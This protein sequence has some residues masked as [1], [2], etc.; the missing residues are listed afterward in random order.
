[1][2][3]TMD[4]STIIDT[5]KLHAKKINAERL[6]DAYEFAA[7]AHD[8]Q[9]RRSGEPYIQHCL[10]ATYTLAKLKVD[11]DTLIA[12]LLHDVPE[13]TMYTIQDVK[14]KFGVEVAYLVNGVTKL[15]KVQYKDNM[16]E[17]Q[18]ESL[19]KMFLVMAK[20]LR[21]VLIKLADRLHNMETLSAVRPEK[22][23]RI[24]KETLEIFAPLADRLGIWDIKWKLEDLCFKYIYP[25]QYAKLN[26]EIQTGSEER[27]KYIERV[28]DTLSKELN[29]AGIETKI[30]GRTKHLY[31]IYMKMIAKK[32]TLSEIYDIFALRI[33]VSDVKNCYAALGIVHDVWKPKPGR[34]KDYIAVPKANGYQSLHTTVFAIDGRLTEFQIRTNEMHE[35]AEYGVAAHWHY[36]TTKQSPGQLKGKFSRAPAEQLSWV[37][38]LVEMQETLKDNREFIEGLKID[39]FKD[40]IFVFT[41]M[42]EVK[43]L[44]AG[45]TCVDFAYAVHTDLGHS[46]M[47]AK[48]NG[49]MVPLDTTLKTGDIIEILASKVPQGPKR[50]WLRFV[51][52]NHARNKIRSW[53]REENMQINVDHGMKLLDDELIRLGKGKVKTLSRQRI[54]EFLGNAEHTTLDDVLA[55]IGEGSL[56]VTNAVRNLFQPEEILRTQQPATGI[57]GLLK[58]TRH[59]AAT[60]A[61]EPRVLIEGQSNMLTHFGKCCSPTAADE[62]V[63]FIT[64][65]KGITIHR[66]NC[67]SLKNLDRDRIIHVSWSTAPATPALYRVNIVVEGSDRI[68]LLRD[69]I[70]VLSDLSINIH[71]LNAHPKSKKEASAI[72]DEFTIEVQNL[73]QLDAAFQKLEKIEGVQRVYRKE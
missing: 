26:T 73:D 53:F 25:V 24:A 52:T 1:M 34:F 28:I 27:E 50:D 22:R 51:V 41:P 6:R 2:L 49:T 37:R 48:V 67:G 72:Y 3:A 5:Q 68:G 23:L 7:K 64:R 32:K 11:E 62:I 46:C 30:S 39:I 33:V 35:E 54:N 12:A 18:V 8:G 65:G 45:S 56:S 71:T 40:R 20:D 43:D 17:H 69:I 10:H 29:A 60:A 19:R 4:I 58:R 31:S 57:R 14:E 55:A 70:A 9:Y 44:P 36:S 38:N 66:L 61:G 63:G 13:D 15:S 21:V 47:G 59:P 16:A 42:G